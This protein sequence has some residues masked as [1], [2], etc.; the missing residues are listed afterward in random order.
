LSNLVAGIVDLPAEVENTLGAYGGVKLGM[1]LRD[2][3]RELPDWSR[4]NP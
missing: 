2:T 4:R 1:I 3:A